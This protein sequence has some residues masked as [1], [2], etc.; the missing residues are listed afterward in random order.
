[1]IMYVL[2]GT[3]RKLVMYHGSLAREDLQAAISLHLCFRGPNRTQQGPQS[4]QP[5][6]LWLLLDPQKISPYEFMFFVPGGSWASSQK[7][8]QLMN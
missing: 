5:H 6:P 4:N 1:M 7:S 8:F 3:F 2:Q